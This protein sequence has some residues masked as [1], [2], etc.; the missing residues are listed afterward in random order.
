VEIEDSFKL[1]EAGKDLAVYFPLI[2]FRSGNAPV[3]DTAFINGVLRV[4]S[5]I[6]L[7]LPY[8][9]HRL[10][11]VPERRKLLSLDELSENEIEELKKVSI[12]CNPNKKFL[13]DSYQINGK[14]SLGMK[15][16]YLLRDTLKVVGLHRVAF[17]PPTCAFF[18]ANKQKL[19]SGGTGHTMK[20]C[21]YFNIPYYSR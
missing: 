2:Y 10:T 8:K 20:V 12:A 6:Q 3:S 5:N 7:V 4:S 13:F 1:E 14:T 9:K 11:K 21:Q 18:Y 19:L 16:A 17:H 15:C